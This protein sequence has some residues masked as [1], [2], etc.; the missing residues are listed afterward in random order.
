[1]SILFNKSAQAAATGT[2]WLLLA[3]LLHNFSA[4][5]QTD[6]QTKSQRK[7]KSDESQDEHQG[8]QRTV[9]ELI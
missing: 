8:W 1:M 9:G 3:P 7:E 6:K 5:R 2:G 4:L